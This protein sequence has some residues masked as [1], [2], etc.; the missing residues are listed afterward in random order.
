MQDKPV[1]SHQI[2]LVIALVGPTGIGKSEV[3]YL[4]AKRLDG[5]IVSADSMQIYKEIDIGTAKPSKSD[6]SMVR[7]HMLDIVSLKEEYSVARFQEDSRHAI[8]EIQGSGKTPLVVGGSGL[9][10]RAI[11]DDLDFPPYTKK[12]LEIRKQ[13]EEE[14]EAKGAAH[15][16]ATLEEIDP[17]T[18]AGIHPND[19]RRV[20]RAIEV[21]MVSGKR[22][23][24]FPKAWVSRESIYDLKM[25]GLRTQRSTLNE[26]IDLRVDRMIDQGLIDEVKDLVDKGFKKELRRKRALGYVEILDYL[27]GTI[28]VDEAVSRIKVKTHRFA[29]RQMTW[30]NADSRVVWFNRGKEDDATKLTDRLESYLEELKDEG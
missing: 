13:L 4:L 16:Y 5:E 7:H 8:S 17:D 21:K 2:P 18:A 30:F 20:I 27:E 1:H 22:F 12:A 6:R 9:Y 15:L 24:D 28:P 14:A 23:S 26:M 25:L 10:I 11:V 3:A 19:I 29:K